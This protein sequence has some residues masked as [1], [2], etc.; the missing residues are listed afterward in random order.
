MK[1]LILLFWNALRRLSIQ[2]MGKLF[3]TLFSRPHLSVL[4]F[5]ATLKTFK[6]IRQK[7]PETHQNSGEGNAYRHALWTSL[8]MVYCCKVS[9]PKKALVWCK[10]ITDL[11]EELFPNTPLERMMDL[12]NNQVG[13]DLFMEMLEGIH[14]QFFEP[15]FIVE[16]LDE[17]IKNALLITSVKDISENRMVYLEKD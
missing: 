8:I 12:H 3:Y 11:H 14:R 6:I 9:S 17:K 4:T 1:K 10:K 16:K 15:S 7:Y 5:Y 13:M 2:K